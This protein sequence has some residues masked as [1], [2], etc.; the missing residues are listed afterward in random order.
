MELLKTVIFTQ[1]KDYDL[2]FV[3]LLFVF[4]EGGRKDV[5]LPEQLQRKKL[6]GPITLV[7][8]SLGAPAGGDSCSRA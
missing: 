1:Y 8:Y 4:R 5:D 3:C 7:A 2:A 6:P